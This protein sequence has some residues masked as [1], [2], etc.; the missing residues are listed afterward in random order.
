MKKIN[1]GLI[2]FGTIGSGV[3]RILTERRAA[4]KALA[5][6]DINLKYICDKDLSSGKSVKVNKK[7]LTRDVKK[8][9]GDAQV[10]IVVELIG[11]IHPAKEIILSAIKNGKDIVTANKAL[12]A[13]DGV[14]IF[15]TARRFGRE[16]MFEASVGG[17]IPIIKALREGFVSNKIGAIYGIINGT[18]NYILSRMSDEG[19]DFKVALKAAQKMGIAEANPTLD[20]SGLDSAHKLIILAGLSFGG[21]VKMNQVYC[22]GI[23]SLEARDIRYAN[24][25]GYAVKLLAITKRS[26]GKI[27]LRVHPTLVPDCHLLANVKDVYNAIYVKGDLTGETLFYGKGAGKLPTASAV[28]S[29]IVDLARLKNGLREDKRMLFP[30]MHKAAKI[31]K[32]DDVESRYYIRFSVEDTPGVLARIAGIL[33][34]NNISIASVSQK[35]ERAANSVPVVIVTHE[36]AE[37]KLRNAL[38]YIDKLPV[39]KKKSVAIRMESL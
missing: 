12:L 29:D 10:D 25:M 32:M 18:C 1:I 30:V 14:V 22:E 24:E 6:V 28:I 5:G 16:V 2:G 36:A 31:K 9:V 15:E 38:R 34:K 37:A 27:E 3:V 17:G 23:L 33:G 21:F 7:L 11:G 26:G 39:T 19:C 20:V 35:E 13:E 8:V 4:L